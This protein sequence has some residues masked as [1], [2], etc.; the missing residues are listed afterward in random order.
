MP[1]SPDRPVGDWIS[2]KAEVVCLQL[3]RANSLAGIEPLDVGILHATAYLVN[4]LSPVI[5]QAP[6]FTDV[7]KRNGLPYIAEL[8]EGLDRLL[9]RRAV[10]VETFAL[11][12]NSEGSYD[13]D[14]KVYLDNATTKR[15]FS[16]LD[17]YKE[18]VDFASLALEVALGLAASDDP[19]DVFLEDA[20]YSDPAVSVNRLIQVAND[21]AGATNL[22]ATTAEW[23]RSVVANGR[24]MSDEEQVNLYMGHLRRLVDATADLGG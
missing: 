17:E 10:R 11:S 23:F 9:T 4:A 14:L 18:E 8:Q 6:V 22:S 13:L 15:I 2:A 3:I 21:E 19:E 16:R 1:T 24:V 5:D 12:L 7:L 20:S